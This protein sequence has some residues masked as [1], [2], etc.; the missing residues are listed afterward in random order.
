[1]ET[2]KCNSCGDDLEGEEIDSPRKDRD[3]T[4]LCDECFENEYTHRCPICEDL[5]AKISPRCLMVLKSVGD[6]VGL[7]DGIYEIVHL[8]LYL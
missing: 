4:V 3:G 2:I 1:M 8:I 5:G 6:N 7:D